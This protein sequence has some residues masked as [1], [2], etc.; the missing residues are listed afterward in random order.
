MKFI[1]EIIATVF[2]I[3][4]LPAGGTLATLFS[5]PLVIWINTQ[6]IVVKM[7]LVFIVG[8]VSVII[9]GF[10]EK[11]IF[12]KK[13]DKKIVVDEIFGFIIAMLEI[14]IK[15]LG[16]LFLGFFIFRILDIYKLGVIK[17][18]QNLNSAVG[19]VADDFLCGIIT[20][21]ILRILLI[22]L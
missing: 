20:N 3:G 19:V 10:A 21:I 6:N 16:V 11:E 22:W 1:I 18:I 13:D 15:N 4:Y 5:F 8:F 12:K 9:S 7:I 14:E 17:K 2:F